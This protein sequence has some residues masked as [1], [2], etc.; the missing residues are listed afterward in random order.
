MAKTQTQVICKNVFKSGKDTAAKDQFTKQ[1]IS[2][3]H[4]TKKAEK[5]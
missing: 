1:W 5:V 4:L 3:I 2:L